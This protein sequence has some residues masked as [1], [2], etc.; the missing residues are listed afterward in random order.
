MSGSDSRHTCRF[1]VSSHELLLVLLQGQTSRFHIV[2]HNPNSLSTVQDT[3]IV[4]GPLHVFHVV[5]A[6]EARDVRF[7]LVAVVGGWK[8]VANVYD[9][10]SDE[11]SWVQFER[12]P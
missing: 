7:G 12:F 6:E 10:H 5:F 11:M 9:D 1:A 2:Q 4:I 3:S 8:L